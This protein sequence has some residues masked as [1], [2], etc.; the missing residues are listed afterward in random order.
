V[1]RDPSWSII[2]WKERNAFEGNP[3]GRTLLCGARGG[4]E[5]REGCTPMGSLS[6]LVSTVG[7]VRKQHTDDEDNQ[8]VALQ[9]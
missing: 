4:W 7:K 8:P 2:H 5:E 3:V 9:T 1:E 6:K